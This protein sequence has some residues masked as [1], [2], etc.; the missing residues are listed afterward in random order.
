M[1]NTAAKPD[2]MRKPSGVIFLMRGRET[3]RCALARQA[4]WLRGLALEATVYALAGLYWFDLGIVGFSFAIAGGFCL[5]AALSAL[6][7]L[8]FRAAHAPPS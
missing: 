1:S 8:Q 7:M 5:F 3:V 2:W 4:Q 6:G